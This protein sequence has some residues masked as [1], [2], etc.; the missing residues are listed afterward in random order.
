MDGI[1]I[2]EFQYASFNIIHAHGDN[3]KNLKLFKNEIIKFKNIIG[4]TQVEPDRNLVNPGG[5]TD[6]DRILYFLKHK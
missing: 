4:T 6:G 1:T 5:F 2:K 3:I